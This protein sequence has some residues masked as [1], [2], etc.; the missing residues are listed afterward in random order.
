MRIVIK[1]GSSTLTH[2]TGKLNLRTIERLVRAMS[3]IK[4][5]GHE[6]IL[7]SS[8]AMAV[9]RT[10]LGLDRKPSSTPKKQAVASVGQSELMAIYDKM[11]SD[12]GYN[13]GQIL[14]TKDATEEPRRRENVIN[15]FNALLSYNCIP[16]VNEND[17]VEVEEIK[18]G[19]ND[20]LSA[21]VATCIEADLLIILSDIHNMYDSDP[22]KNPDAKPI[23]IVEEITE[24]IIS[25]AQGTSSNV[26]TGGMITKIY[27]AKTATEKGIPV[28]V[29]YG[30]NPEILYDILENKQVG[31]L[32]C[33]KEKN[34]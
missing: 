31:T 8:G 18:F 19:D 10:K 11:F 20:T 6:I 24:K 33:A 21:I 2:S 1:I 13:V 3:D 26:G 28:Y 30:K 5:R 4:N 27:A 16:I 22:K 12:Y 14:L 9:G 7:V 17:S 29:A 15:T 25:L 32:F 23:Y 34:K